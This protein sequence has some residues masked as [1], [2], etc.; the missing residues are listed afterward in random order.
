[1]EFNINRYAFSNVRKKRINTQSNY[2][3]VY[4]YEIEK[5]NFVYQSYIPKYKWSKYHKTEKEAAK[6]VDLKLIENGESPI[7]I[8]IKKP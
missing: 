7:N 3:Y 6:A 5:G 2:K 1:M 4:T 8:L